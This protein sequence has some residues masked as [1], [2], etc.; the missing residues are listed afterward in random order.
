MHFA[1]CSVP[2]T[3]RMRFNALTFREVLKSKPWALKFDQCGSIADR[4]FLENLALQI[5]NPDLATRRCTEQVLIQVDQDFG[6]I[7]AK[8]STLEMDY[9]LIDP[10][11][12][13]IPLQSRLKQNIPG[14]W[15]FLVTRELSRA[16]I[17]A[18]LDS[19]I[20]MKPDTMREVRGHTTHQ[21]PIPAALK[22]K[23]TKW[24]ADYRFCRAALTGN[25]N[26]NMP[27]SP[28]MFTAT[29]YEGVIRYY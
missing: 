17:E 23:G 2:S 21:W 25:F 9:L 7:L 16:E 12:I 11:N 15:E 4:Q 24:A 3:E 26:W 28:W 13:M 14:D 8:F 10:A 20:E 18:A 19:D 27:N 1:S 6:E 29:F 5:P 22:W